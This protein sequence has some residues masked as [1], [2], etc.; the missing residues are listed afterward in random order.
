MTRKQI[1]FRIAVNDKKRELLKEKIMAPDTSNKESSDLFAQIN[2]L[3]REG[4]ALW[5]LLPEYA[6]IEK[7][8]PC[9]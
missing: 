1:E 5:K 8:T 9:A 3:T 6:D 4:M 2:T 7:D